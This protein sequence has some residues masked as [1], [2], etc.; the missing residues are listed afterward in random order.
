MHILNDPSFFLTNKTGAPQ[1]EELGL[2]NPLSKSY[3]SCSDNSFI[4]D[5]ANRY[6]ARATGQLLELSR[7]R[8]LLVKPEEGPTSPRETLQENLGR[9]NKNE[10]SVNARGW[11]YAIGNAEK[12]GNASR[13][14][15]S[16][17]IMGNSYDV[18][19]A[20]GKILGVDIIIRGCTLNF[21]NHPFN[22]DL[23][24]VELGSFDV[25]IG[26][27]WLRRMSDLFSTDIRQEGGRQ[28]RR[29]AT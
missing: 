25:I 21:L 16:N 27:D 29:K 7:F 4:S 14:P 1:G 8:I 18:E 3:C 6:G 26:M 24:P 10:E 17:V 13:D 5:E 28:V 9:L 11:V 12:K 23:L 20:D 19:F 22:I 2:I 15:D